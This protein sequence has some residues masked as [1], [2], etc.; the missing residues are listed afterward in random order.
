M[1]A[2][3][4][5]WRTTIAVIFTILQIRG[6]T[7]VITT[8]VY[9]VEGQTFDFSCEYPHSWQSNAKYFCLFDD[10]D[11]HLIRTDKHDQWETEGRFSLYDNTT[12]AFFIV[13]VDKLVPGDSGIYWCGVD[14]SSHPDHISAKQLYVSRELNKPLFLTAVMCVAAILFVFLFTL[15]L[16]WAVKRQRLGPRQ[17]RE[18]TITKLDKVNR[19]DLTCKKQFTVNECLVSSQ[20]S[21]DYETMTPGVGTEPEHRCTCLA[22]DCAGPSGLWET[23]AVSVTGKLWGDITIKCSHSNA[24]S[25]VKYFCKGAC[26]NEDVLINSREKTKYPKGKYSII[27]K[28][29]TFSVTISRLTLDDAGSYWCGIDRVGLDTYNKVVLTVIEEDND[30]SEEAN[31]TLPE[32]LVYIGASLGAVVLAL[33]VVLLIFFRHR[34]KDANTSS[35]KNHNT[36]YASPSSLKQNAKHSTSSSA[37]NEDDDTD[38]TKTDGNFGLSA[39]QHQDTSRDHAD[40]CYFSGAISSEPQNQPDDLFYTTVSLNTHTHRSSVTPRP[41]VVTYSTVTHISTDEPVIYST[42]SLLS[43]TVT[44]VVHFNNKCV[45]APVWQ[46]AHLGGSVTINCTYPREEEGPIK[47]F[48]RQNE[49][50]QCKTL[51]EA[52]T[53]GYTKLS[54]FSLKDHEEQG[55]YTVTMSMLTRDDAGR[56]RCA[57]QTVKDNA[58]KYLTEI[59]L[60]IF[61][62]DDK[63]QTIKP[64][65]RKTAKMMC[66]YP[67]SHVNNTKHLCKGENPFNCSE[68]IHTEEG[69]IDATEGRLYIR[70]SKRS[71]YFYVNIN[72]LR[73]S[74]SGTYWCSFGRGRCND[75]YT[76]TDLFVADRTKIRGPPTQPTAA[77]PSPTSPPATLHV[78]HS[79]SGDLITD[80]QLLFRPAFIHNSPENV[81]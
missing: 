80:K 12:G 57:L 6:L 59:H 68:L 58:M 32:K 48:C 47:H 41:A 51:I 38:E 31:A 25:N 44:E 27:D 20:T 61:N 54:R 36:I 46:T 14:V 11:N 70:D 74:D 45:G 22:S 78:G 23:E 81:T 69:E 34:N 21:S 55:V 28:G 60:H 52:H 66:H 65:D 64:N 39:D 49:D 53:S 17:N 15:C 67:E 72:N 56:Y 18:L 7:S 62:R 63:T 2:A 33:A 3:W 4:I 24:I 9:G 29:N 37:A 8:K 76:R 19:S 42:V 40:N 77:S 26:T 13:R 43:R 50:V 79:N 71:K 10:N 5:S 16:L 73:T 35:G 75:G 30:T 1:G